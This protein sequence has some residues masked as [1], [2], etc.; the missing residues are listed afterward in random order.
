MDRMPAVTH[1]QLN[2]HSHR[3]KLVLTLLVVTMN[4]P[5]GLAQTDS[6]SSTHSTLS[7]PV[8]DETLQTIRVNGSDGITAEEIFAIFR[9]HT[10]EIRYCL[11]TAEAKK[12]SPQFPVPIGFTLD[13]DGRPQKMKILDGVTNL[14]RECVTRRV[15]TWTFPK[16]P[17]GPTQVTMS[18]AHS[19]F[20]H[21]GGDRGG[22]QNCVRGLGPPSQR[23]FGKT[24]MSHL[25]SAK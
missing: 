5:Y 8:K 16:S 4:V 21:Q 22:D 25:P 3:F 15:S 1:H 17:S 20:N 23:G 11:K 7:S 6:E 13:A 19:D 12:V 2:T 10:I 9:N 24:Q 18:L 14:Y